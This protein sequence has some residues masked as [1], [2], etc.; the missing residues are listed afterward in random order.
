MANN[1]CILVM[2]YVDRFQCSRACSLENDI[3][4]NLYNHCT[5]SILEYKFLI[6]FVL[7]HFKMNTSTF[8]G[9]R[10]GAAQVENDDICLS[11][12]GDSDED[13]IPAPG[14]ENSSNNIIILCIFSFL[15]T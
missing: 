14:D 12:S 11:E 5:D 15:F 3:L 2:L 7:L 6:K 8:Y 10:T 4:V 1:G 9:K 13:Y